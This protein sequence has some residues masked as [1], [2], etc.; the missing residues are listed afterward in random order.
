MR[1]T[2]ARLAA[3]AVL[4]VAA[5]F[6]GLSQI[7]AAPMGDASLVRARATLSN[8]AQVQWRRFRRRR[9]R[10]RRFYP[11][12]YG[13]YPGYAYYPYRRYRHSYYPGPYISFGF[14][15]FRFGFW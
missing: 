6:A 12:A 15:P 1:T 14:G 13:Y 4:S 8:A 9:Y 7:A 10:A 5:V 11:Y 3:L 2:I